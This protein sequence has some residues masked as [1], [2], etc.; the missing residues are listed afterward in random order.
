M[1]NTLKYKIGI[2]EHLLL[3]HE[4]KKNTYVQ[5]QGFFIFNKSFIEKFVKELDKIHDLNL[6]LQRSVPMIYKPAPWKNYSFG[7]YYLK[8]TK[9]A[10]IFNN[11]NEPIKYLKRSN[12]QNICNVLDFLSSVDWR[13]NRRVLEVVEHVWSIGGGLGE[14]PKRYNER[15]ITPEMIRDAGFR[16][17]LKLLKEH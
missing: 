9:L 7:G 16:E 5:K 3:K 15:E 4:I 11:Y 17:K 12:L 13:V 1:S 14:I 2:E 6:Q 8:Q 10:K